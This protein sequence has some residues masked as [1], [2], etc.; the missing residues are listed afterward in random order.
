LVLRQAD[1][2]NISIIPGKTGIY[3]NRY[4][5]PVDGE[6]Y[7]DYRVGTVS[8]SVFVPEFIMKNGVI[9]KFR[10]DGTKVEKIVEENIFIR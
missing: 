1:N 7:Q 4:S 3:K 8:E 9:Y 5:L 6:L 10:Y 2:N